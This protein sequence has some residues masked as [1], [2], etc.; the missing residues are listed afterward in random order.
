MHRGEDA[1][2]RCIINHSCPKQN[3]KIGSLPIFIGSPAFGQHRGHKFE[4]RT[5][6]V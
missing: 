3:M 5:F 4:K 2:T 6:F 1:A